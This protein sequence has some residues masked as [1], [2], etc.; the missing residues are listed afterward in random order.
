M[1]EQFTAAFRLRSSRSDLPPGYVERHRL[2]STL[3]KGVQKAVTVVSAG[4]GY[5]KTLAVSAWSRRDT[6]PGPVAWLTVGD[7]YDIQGLWTDV[8]DA[9][10]MS[11]ISLSGPLNDIIPAPQFGPPELNR[12]VGALSRLPEP[13]RGPD[14]R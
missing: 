6:M 2:S 3:D 13:A 9:L 7:S 8:L 10:R 5:G 1:A 11:D 14:H 12:I 4:P